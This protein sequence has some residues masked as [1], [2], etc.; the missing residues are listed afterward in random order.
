MESFLQHLQ[1]FSI[2]N[3][4]ILGR[5]YRE[6]IGETENPLQTSPSSP[7]YHRDYQKSL[8]GDILPRPGGLP[9]A[10]WGMEALYSREISKMDTSTE[11]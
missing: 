8:K 4:P 6:G 5:S 9:R 2:R 10:I 3:I 11:E 1:M 7:W